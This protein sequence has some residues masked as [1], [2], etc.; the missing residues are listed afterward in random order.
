MSFSNKRNHD[1]FSIGIKLYFLRFSI[2]SISRAF[3]F[4]YHGTPFCNWNSPRLAIKRRAEIPFCGTS[5][6]RFVSALKLRQNSFKRNPRYLPRNTGYSNVQRCLLYSVLL[7]GCSF[8]VSITLAN[9]SEQ[10]PSKLL[11]EGSCDCFS[12]FSWDQRV[13]L[14][15]II[16]SKFFRSSGRFCL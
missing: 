5:P 8:Y 13:L 10:Y 6:L 14:E 11:T 4:K 12:E 7:R 16:L 3:F 9:L 2:F 1:I 15:N